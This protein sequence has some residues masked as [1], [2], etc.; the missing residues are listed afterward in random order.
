MKFTNMRLTDPVNNRSGGKNVFFDNKE[1][2]TVQGYVPFGLQTFK[3]MKTFDIQLK[4][5]E[6]VSYFKSID[7]YIVDEARKNSF[8]WFNKSIH[9]SV[10]TELYRSPMRKNKDFPPL[11]KVKIPFKNEMNLDKIQKGC[12]LKI[13]IQNS[14][15]YF[16]NS[17]FGT[18]WVLESMEVLEKAQPAVAV[19]GYSF[20]DE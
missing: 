3:S 9:E 5:D 19:S 15:I 2:A 8:R 14:G 7:E 17:S 12:N 16:S 1:Y 6:L 4:D 11:L 20:I 18:G 10:I 13:C